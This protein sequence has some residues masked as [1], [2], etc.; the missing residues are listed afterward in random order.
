MTVFN[1]R[2]ATREHYYTI[3]ANFNTNSPLQVAACTTCLYTAASS[4]A[5]SAINGLDFSIR[6]GA[7]PSTGTVAI[8]LLI[9]QDNTWTLIRLSYLISGRSD[10]TLGFISAGTHHLMQTPT[11][12]AGTPTPSASNPPSQV[13]P[14]PRPALL[15]SLS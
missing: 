8:V 10:F 11:S 7:G 4:L 9:D 3:T 6:G 1:A 2:T 12:P 15:S 5:I 14:L 13:G